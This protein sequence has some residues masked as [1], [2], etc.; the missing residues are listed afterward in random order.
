[1][2]KRFKKKL[3]GD[4]GIEH[5]SQKESQVSLDLQKKNKKQKT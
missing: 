5:E 3:V 1:M 4:L 2:F